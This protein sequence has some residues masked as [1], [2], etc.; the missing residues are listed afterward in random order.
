MLLHV[1]PNK[2]ITTIYLS[3]SDDKKNGHLSYCHKYLSV[4]YVNYSFLKKMKANFYIGWIIY[5]FFVICAN[6]KS[7]IGKFTLKYCVLNRE[8]AKILCYSFWFD[9]TIAVIQDL[10]NLNH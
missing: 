9:Q 8:A 3:T 7:A 6:L 4:I 2:I 5:F 10:L 1:N